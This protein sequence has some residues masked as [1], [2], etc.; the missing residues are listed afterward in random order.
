[1]SLLNRLDRIPLS[2]PHYNLLLMGRLGYTFDVWTRPSSRSF[3]R[4]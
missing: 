3:F 1:M 2:R 4:R